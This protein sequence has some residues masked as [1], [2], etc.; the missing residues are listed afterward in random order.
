MKAI[1]KSK[2]YDTETAIEIGNTGSKG[3]SQSDFNYWDAS[4]YRTKNDN[5]FVA[6]EGGP[7][8]PYGDTYVGESRY[9]EGI[10]AM[11][12]IEAFEWCQCHGLVDVI[13][14]YFPGMV[15]DA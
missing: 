8:S 12:E 6:G 3:I 4:L 2:R 15:V 11:T 5:Y 14:K 13:E 1:I 7:L 10:I 9:G